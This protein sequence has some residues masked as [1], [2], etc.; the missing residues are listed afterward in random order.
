MSTF[1]ELFDQIDEDFDIDEATISRCPVIDPQKISNN[2]LQQI[3]SQKPQ[4]KKHKYLSIFLV[5]AAVSAIL[6]SSTVI[7][8]Q[9]L[10]PDFTEKYNGDVSALTIYEPEKFRFT[11]AND[12]LSAY[13][14]GLVGD[15]NNIVASVSLTKAD[16][17]TFLTDEDGFLQ[18]EATLISMLWSSDDWIQPEDGDYLT[19]LRSMHSTY[20]YEY[21]CYTKCGDDNYLILEHPSTLECRLSE[22]KKEIMLYINI[23]A[24]TGASEGGITEL[25]FDH[26]YACKNS[27]LLGTYPDWEESTRQKADDYCLEQGI[28]MGENC[29]VV[30]ED[31]M[32]QLY[33]IEK[34]R[35]DMP[36]D[37]SFTMD[38][39]MT[40]PITSVIEAD[41]APDFLRPDTSVEMTLSPFHLQLSSERLLAKEDV[42]ALLTDYC[43]LHQ[44]SEEDTQKAVAA[45]DDDFFSIDN[46]Y[47]LSVFQEKQRGEDY[48]FLDSSSSY[49]TMKDQH[50]YYLVEGNTS[51]GFYTEDGVMLTV[52][53]KMTLY[54]SD[55]PMEVERGKTILD[56]VKNSSVLNPKE[57]DSITINGQIIYRQGQDGHAVVNASV[58][59][60]SR[61]HLVKGSEQTYTDYFSHNELANQLMRDLTFKPVWYYQ[62]DTGHYQV[63]SMTL[64]VCGTEE[65]LIELIKQLE[66]N[67]E[68]DLIIANISVTKENDAS[69]QRTM[70]VEMNSYYPDTD[71]SL[72]EEEATEVLLQQITYTDNGDYLKQY[73]Q[74][75]ASPYITPLF[76]SDEIP[77]Y[78]PDMNHEEQ[79]NRIDFGL[80]YQ[81]APHVF[82]EGY[83]FAVYITPYKVLLEAIET[84]PFGHPEAFT[85][86]EFIDYEQ[87]FI[88][89]KDGTEYRF[90]DFGQ[91]QVFKDTYFTQDWILAY[92]DQPFDNDLRLSENEKIAATVTLDIHNIDIIMLNGDTLYHSDT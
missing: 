42:A 69:G 8:T 80:E 65:Q 83:A 51:T 41:H 67:Q 85:D 4:S 36:F 31:G 73:F 44:Y 91:T 60:K 57:V 58:F 7:A 76:L 55:I 84:D 23:N 25:S 74:R 33:E 78:L 26:L 21:V 82:Q 18:P 22:D 28:N 54:F 79:A 3:H 13:F 52:E 6:V 72:S 46:A 43:H 15:Q 38:F 10:K 40:E 90:V 89:M 39:E 12:T 63:L 87:S 66:K 70:M 16:N 34:I 19:S 27:R 86:T 20:D 49:V 59:D 77:N 71:N 2:V 50:I 88:R 17:T 92:T 9:L 56:E 37:L 48:Y 61:F 62:T 5:A 53:D 32:Y 75:G 64:T 11:S 81:A 29:R 1:R 45:A 35:Y 30:Y 14:V 68:N 24:E 47:A